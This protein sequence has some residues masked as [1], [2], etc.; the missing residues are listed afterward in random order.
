MAMS[1]R[2]AYASAEYWLT[3]WKTSGFPWT[4]ALPSPVPGIGQ[5]SVSSAWSAK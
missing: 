5:L 1:P 2:H 4:Y 3:P